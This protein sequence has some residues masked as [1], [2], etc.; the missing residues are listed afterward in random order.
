MLLKLAAYITERN[1]FFARAR[2]HDIRLS[3]AGVKFLFLVSGVV[4]GSTGLIVFLTDV[5][6][7]CAAAA[8]RRPFTLEQALRSPSASERAEAIRFVDPDIHSVEVAV[9]QAAKRGEKDPLLRDRLNEALI[10]SQVP[11]ISD[12]LIASLKNDES[13]LV[14]VG[15]AQELGN[16]VQNSN[17][18]ESLGVALLKN[19]SRDVRMAAARSLGISPTLAAAEFLNQAVDDPE[20][21]VRAQ[22]AYSLKRFSDKKSE[23]SL[24]LLKRDSDLTVRKIA[25]GDPR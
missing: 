1:T 11:E 6:S 7:V 23:K 16:Y 10:R 9:L 21:H 13:V 24:R 3:W 2:R 15:A 8:D 4:V 18:I 19:P 12:E 14:Q 25:E 5:F 20:A 17:V 22:V